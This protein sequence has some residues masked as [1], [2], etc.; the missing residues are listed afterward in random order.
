[1]TTVADA[2]AQPGLHVVIYG[3]RG[4]GK[5]S[6]ANVLQSVLFVLDQK[7]GRPVPRFVAKVNANQGDSFQTLWNR[8]F[9]EVSWQQDKPTMGFIPQPGQKRVTL[10]DAFGVGD[11]PTIDDVRRVLS[12]IPGSVFIFD[13]FDRGS[14]QLRADFT[15]L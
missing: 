3:E 10:A 5:S 9:N 15:D 12:A 13:E 6:L 8:I 14:D 2:V 7:V 4:V 11:K 1:M